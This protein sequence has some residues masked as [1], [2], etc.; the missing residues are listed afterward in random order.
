M[1]GYLKRLVTSGAAY[2]AAGLLA[3]LLALFT[4]PLYTHA[5][6]TADY[7]YAETLLTFVILGSIVVRAG[8]GEGLVRFWF[9]DDDVDRR[10]ELARATTAFV[11]FGTTAVLAVGL[12]LSGPL[13]ELLLGVRDRE[14]MGAGL[15]GLWAF[16][17]LEVAYA[18][19]RV[20]ERRRDYLAASLTNVVLTVGLTVTLV[21]GLDGGATAYVLG[22]YLASTV[23]LLGVW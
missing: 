11:A 17:N 12:A 22:N 9:E 13:S 3:S 21:V 19:M 8:A 6:T 14:L 7:G 18:L 2:Q 4:L 23:V 5:L 16:T 15:L 1:G 20:E 10:L